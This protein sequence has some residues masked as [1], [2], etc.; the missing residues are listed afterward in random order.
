M[1]RGTLR[2]R[3]RVQLM[4]F[5]PHETVL[6][7]TLK[8]YATNVMS[9]VGGIFAA[10]L[11]HNSAVKRI[12]YK[13]DISEDKYKHKHSVKGISKYTERGW[14]FKDIPKEKLPN[15]RMGKDKKVKMVDYGDIYRSALRSQCGDAQEIPRKVKDY[16]EKSKS[17]FGVST[18]VEKKSKIEDISYVDHEGMT[19]SDHIPAGVLDWVHD[20]LDGHKDVTP[21]AVWEEREKKQFVLLDLWFGGAGALAIHTRYRLQDISSEEY[22]WPDSDPQSDSDATLVE[23][24][25]AD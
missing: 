20:A 16:F 25:D 5:P 23:G 19:G 1:L 8:F 3:T 13:L 10:H 15:R 2:D 9:F 22:N 7:Q 18:W 21:K 4:L 14:T 17:A 24:S 11:Y 12:S 6:H